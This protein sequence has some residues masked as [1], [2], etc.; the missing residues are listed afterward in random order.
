PYVDGYT[1]GVISREGPLRVRLASQVNTLHETNTE[2][3]RNLFTLHSGV[4]GKTRWIDAR[5]VEFSPESRLVPSTTYQVTF[6]LEKVAE[7]PSDL[8]RFIF[9]FKVIDPSYHVEVEGLK[10]QTSSSTDLLK[11]TGAISLADVEDPAHIEKI[12]A[13]T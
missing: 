4:K 8:R 12:L 9:D 5:T 10:S 6:D 1:T 3:T 11:L 2:D 7:V 13:A